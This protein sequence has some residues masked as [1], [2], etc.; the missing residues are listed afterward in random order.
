[1]I[2]ITSVW[3]ESEVKVKPLASRIL[4][5]T[6]Q[7]TY[8][9]IRIPMPENN[10]SDT[11]QLKFLIAHNGFHNRGRVKMNTVLW[12]QGTLDSA[13]PLKSLFMSRDKVLNY[14]YK[15]MISEL[16]ER[17]ND[18][19]ATRHNQR[20]WLKMT[21]RQCGSQPPELASWIP[22]FYRC[23]LFFTEVRIAEYEK[24]VDELNLSIPGLE[25]ENV[26]YPTHQS[27][28]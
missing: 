28:I 3:L 12:V 25:R 1:M 4:F 20:E 13:H 15:Q 22:G 5:S 26:I 11:A 18:I 2:D 19:Q 23:R 21:N 16:G 14:E 6:K 27:S 10:A 17:A 24:L 7:N 9:L 8:L